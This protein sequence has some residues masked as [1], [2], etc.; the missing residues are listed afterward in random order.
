MTEI[1][2]FGEVE[3]V[4][5][6]VLV[7]NQADMI[8]KSGERVKYFTETSLLAEHG[9]SALIGLQPSGQRILW[10]TAATPAALMENV[11]RMKVD[12]KGV[13][14]IAL[15]HGHWDHTGGLTAVLQAM[16]RR[17]EPREWSPETTSAEV[18]D[19]VREHRV[20]VVAH[21]AAFRER[22][23]VDKEGKKFGPTLPPPERTWEELGAHIVRSE[24]PYRLAEGCWTTGYVP[25]R[26]FETSGRSPDRY[27]RVDGRLLRDDL[28]DDQAIV[29]NLKD[30]GLVV[31]AGCAHAGIVNTVQYAR[32]ITGVDR[33]YAVLGGF[34]LAKAKP[35]E[36]DQTI[37][38]VQSWA[39]SLIAPCHCTGFEPICRFATEMPNVF[40][41]G[42][43]GV[44]YTL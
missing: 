17:A 43:V 26:S 22:W 35:D 24:G 6:T 1:Q 34:H 31:V 41:R 21:P 16:D 40:V 15:S 28:E 19:W 29:V 25:R 10:D 2:D 11:R 33:V 18:D 36:I 32:E 12:L 39:P 14:V 38:A 42:V 4:V 23:K 5:I 20:P 3:H 27:Y 37:A 13:D 44:T 30:R 9:F 7:D 8:V